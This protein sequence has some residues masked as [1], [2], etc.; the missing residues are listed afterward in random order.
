M[1][2]NSTLQS[3]IAD[4]LEVLDG[5]DYAVAADT[6]M[7]DLGLN[8]DWVDTVRGK[9]GISGIMEVPSDH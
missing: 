3:R 4:L 7:A 5:T 6:I 2:D 9:A 1:K 8:V